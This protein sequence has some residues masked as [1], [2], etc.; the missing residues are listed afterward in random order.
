MTERTTTRPPRN[1]RPR[2]AKRRQ[3]TI[4]QQIAARTRPQEAEA[5]LILIL[6][7]FALLMRWPNL[8]RLPH[9][10]DEIGEIRWT[11]QIYTGQHFPLTAQVKYF[12]PIHHYLLALCFGVFGPSVTL[13]RTLVCIIGALTVALTYLIGRELGGWKVGAVGAALLAT[14]P[15]H[16]VVNSHVAWENSTT[17]FYA[18]LCYYTLLRA[19]R[20]LPPTPARDN[21]SFWP[22]GR[23]LLLCAFCGGLMLQTHLGTILLAPALLGALGY[24]LYRQQYWQLLRTPWPY[25]SLLVALVAYSPVLIDNLRAGMAGFQRAKGRDYAYVAD[26]TLG[27]Y[28]YNLRNLCYELARM[29]SNPFRT[30]ERAL[31]YF[32]SP[33]MLIAV[34]LALLGLGLLIRRH[35][36]LPLLA[37]FFTAAIMPYYNHAY[38][39]DGDRYL[40]TGRYVAYLLPLLTIATATGALALATAVVHLGQRFLTP[41]KGSLRAWW[42]A[43]WIALPAGLILLLILYP[44]I[45]LRRYYTHEGQND[46]DN[47]TFLETIQ[48][49]RQARGTGNAPVLIGPLFEKVDLKDGATA[50]E[51][52][53]ILLTLDGIPHTTLT[54]PAQQIAQIGDPINPDDILAQPIIIMMRD[55]CIPIRE[56]APMLRISERLRLRELYWEL[57]SYYGVYRYMRDL[58]LGDRCFPAGGATA[59]D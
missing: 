54:D 22:T 51:I 41:G 6:F 50:L 46:P 25:L 18:T 3:R 7:G 59:G 43:A 49:V 17:P 42:R 10:T 12:G 52:L 19:I 29:I 36:P 35:Q 40:L 24:A 39:V 2:P 16:I 55:Q 26:P 4:F 5:L 8:M 15:Q 56:T 11:W 47:A 9:F 28:L 45:P 21:R 13:P 38:G 53:D 30:P 1:A 23:W 44:I 58:P 27:T 20:A 33:Y 32:T 14:L 34:V 48:I 31:H 57:P 37:I